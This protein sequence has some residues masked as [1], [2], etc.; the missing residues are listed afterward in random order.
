MGLLSLQ[1]RR[2][3]VRADSIFGARQ[4]VPR[5]K[6]GA[7]RC[8]SAQT[9]RRPALTRL[10]YAAHPHSPVAQALP[11]LPRNRP[12]NFTRSPCLVSPARARQA[13]RFCHA[14][15]GAAP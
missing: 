2:A 9:P 4:R 11:A 8:A 1:K 10:V 3:R 15:A 12:M 5:T 14:N 13:L 7:W 6:R